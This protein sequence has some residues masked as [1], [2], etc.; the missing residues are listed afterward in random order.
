MLTF[1]KDHAESL[2]ATNTSTPNDKPADSGRRHPKHERKQDPSSR[3]KTGI[4]MT[5]ST[6]NYRWD[7]ALCPAE[8]HPLYMCPTWNGYSVT[9]RLGH[10]KDR[11]LCCNCL[12]PGHQ[13]TD[14]RNKYRC[15]ECGQSHHT[16][17]HQTSEEKATPV[18]ASLS[19]NNPEGLMPTAQVLLRGPQGQEVQVRAL[20]DFGAGSSLISSDLIK[21]LNLPKKTHRREFTGV[22]ETPCATSYH[23]T[24]L[25]ISPIFNRNIKIPCNP[26]IVNR[27]VAVLP[28]APISPVINLHHLIG[29]RLA[30]TTCHIPGK[31]DLLLGS[32]M[33][34]RILT[35]N[36]P[37]I[38]PH[39]QPTAISTSFGWILSGA[40]NYN[41]APKATPS[42]HIQPAPPPSANTTTP[43]LG[44]NG[45]PPMIDENFLTTYQKAGGAE[46]GMDLPAWGEYCDSHLDFNHGSQIPVPEEYQHY[47][48]LYFTT[49]KVLSSSDQ[50]DAAETLPCK[51][52]V[53]EDTAEPACEKPLPDA[54]LPSCAM[55]SSADSS[56]P[57]TST[58][59]RILPTITLHSSQPA[60]K[61]EP[62][63][64]TLSQPL[65][66]AGLTHDVSLQT[67]STA[68]STTT[69]TTTAARIPADIHL[70]SSTPAAKEELVQIPPHHLPSLHTTTTEDFVGNYQ[71]SREVCSG[72]TGVLSSS[73]PELIAP[74][75]TDVA[76]TYNP[77]RDSAGPLGTSYPSVRLPSSSLSTE[78]LVRALGDTSGNYQPSKEDYSGNSGIHCP[79]NGT[80][81]SLSLDTETVAV[82]GDTLGIYDPMSSN[83]TQQPLHWQDDLH[84][85]Q[86]DEL[87]T[88]DSN[89]SHSQLDP[90]TD[91]S[92][93]LLQNI[94]TSHWNP[95]IIL[96]FTI[97]IILSG[98]PASNNNTSATTSSLVGNF[99]NMWTRTM[100]LDSPLLKYWTPAASSISTKYPGA[101][102]ST[103]SNSVLPS[104]ESTNISTFQQTSQPIAISS[105]RASHT[106][107]SKITTSDVNNQQL[108]T[109]LSP[110][111]LTTSQT[112]E[113]F[114]PINSCSSTTSHLESQPLQHLFLY[115]DLG[116]HGLQL[117]QDLKNVQR[118]SPGSMFRHKCLPSA[119]TVASHLN[120]ELLLPDDVIPGSLCLH[121]PAQTSHH[122]QF[123]PYT[124]YHWTG[125]V[126]NIAI[127]GKNTVNQSH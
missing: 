119:Q 68:S 104:E 115:Q 32:E 102:A 85:T 94:S 122:K 80:G 86:G 8:K 70:L 9:Q 35:N 76:G 15:R 90:Q 108:T 31:V 105:F 71:P 20:I 73:S 56:S 124:F 18:N 39:N 69:L 95:L 123:S 84:Q 101:P 42:H 117:H 96:L 109:C 65:P 75:L 77:G 125:Q 11:N 16:T 53:T 127:F 41:S 91:G 51:Q 26:A 87:Q 33:T 52:Q 7:C 97:F 126:K 37:R 24:T 34:S 47:T 12:I 110:P 54:G 25:N 19:D 72:F 78:Q 50:T 64:T 6:S 27:V 88:A 17:L 118:S 106:S 2:A 83:Q 59:A 103:S 1:L 48:P 46:T 120:P 100:D 43:L 82:W 22:Q 63:K 29:L 30:D 3:Y 114:S 92:P 4:H 60:A 23:S 58:A 45:Q 28:P 21:Q 107:T 44:E 10:A 55:D 38:G 62:V 13:A 81:P 61:E 98:L 121:K 116:D 14:C 67:D 93:P 79:L 40:V 74:P 112:G 49:S 111:M 36:S 113:D 89:V 99:S 5:T 66:D 57:P